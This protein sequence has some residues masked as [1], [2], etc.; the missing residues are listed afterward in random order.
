ME[1]SNY[2]NAEVVTDPPNLGKL[3]NVFMA[4]VIA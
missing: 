4:L 2:F 3:A 1:G